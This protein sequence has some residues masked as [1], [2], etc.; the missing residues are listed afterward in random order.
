MGASQTSNMHV[1]HKQT[2]LKQL[3]LQERGGARVSF[4]NRLLGDVNT[5]GQWATF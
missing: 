4:S 3:L 2:T 5:A 1:F